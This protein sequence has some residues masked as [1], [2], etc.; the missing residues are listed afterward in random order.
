MYLRNSKKIAC[1]FVLWIA[2]GAVGIAQNDAI[3]ASVAQAREAMASGNYDAAAT[4]LSAA[5]EAS[6]AVN[7]ASTAALAHALTTIYLDLNRPAEAHAPAAR[8]F[9]IAKSNPN[10]GV[11]PLVAEL[12]LA[13]AEV[14]MGKEE[15]PAHLAATIAAAEA[16]PELQG[17]AYPATVTLAE[18]AFGRG[19]YAAATEAWVAAER[20]AAMAPNPTVA[21]AQALYMKAASV[22]LGGVD[23]GKGSAGEVRDRAITV[24]DDLEAAK[25]L[26]RAAAEENQG[27]APADAAR[28]H[29]AET[30]AWESIFNAKIRTDSITVP[31]KDENAREFEYSAVNG[32]RLCEV[33]FNTDPAP[34]FVQTGRAAGMSAAVV[35][36]DLDEDGRTTDRRIVS[37]VPPNNPYAT[38][39]GEVVEHWFASSSTSRRCVTPTRVYWT[40]SRV[41]Q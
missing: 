35:E 27:D 17:Y 25:R 23:R 21:R 19:D 34:V 30:L 2:T 40:G 5:L 11:D 4:A 6:E 10:A 15:G 18:S 39:I 1:A 36:F 20:S 7:G 38:A 3:N 29:Y 26:L 12:W 9:E 31:A 28:Q 37:A 41:I 33:R 8:A 22:F 16:R 13:R 24:R 32:E 14:G